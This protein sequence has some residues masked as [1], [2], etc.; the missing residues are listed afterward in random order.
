MAKSLATGIGRHGKVAKTLAEGIGG[1]Q[2]SPK[3][4]EMGIGRLLEGG[5]TPATGTFPLQDRAVRHV[6]GRWKEW[7]SARLTGEWAVEGSGKVLDAHVNGHWQVSASARCTQ[8]WVVEKC[9]HCVLGCG[10]QLTE[11]VRVSGR[12]WVYSGLD[13]DFAIGSC[14]KRLS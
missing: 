12:P 7:E 8:T 10:A 9:G 14:F 5:K 1:S 2:P 13:R 6:N 3:K 4:T 11:C